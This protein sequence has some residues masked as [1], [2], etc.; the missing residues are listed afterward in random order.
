M[1][2]GGYKATRKG[3]MLIVHDVPIFAVCYRAPRRDLEGEGSE[4]DGHFD[5]KWIRRAAVDVMRRHEEDHYYPP[6]HIR[7]HEDSPFGPGDPARPAGTFAVTRV[8][9]MLFEGEPRLT[10]FADLRFTDPGATYDVEGFRLPFR[11]V[12]ILNIDGKPTIDSLALLDTEV[13]YLKLPNLELGEIVDDPSVPTAPVAHATFAQPWSIESLDGGGPMIACFSQGTRASLL[14]EDTM[15]MTKTKQKPAAKFGAGVINADDKAAKFAEDGD[16]DKPKDEDMEGDDGFDIA[17]VLTAIETRAISLEDWDSLKAAIRK[18]DEASIADET[19]EPEAAPAS[20]PGGESMS[21]REIVKALMKE[22]NSLKAQ[23]VQ[24]KADV[25]AVRGDRQRD[26]D[27]ATAKERLEGRMLGD[28]EQTL[29]QHHKK[30]GREAFKDF[31][32]ELAKQHGIVGDG[33]D[34]ESEFQGASDLAMGF[35][36]RGT[37]AVKLAQDLEAQ[38]KWLVEHTRMAT[39]L[40]DFVKERMEKALGAA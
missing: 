20:L 36:D 18:A 32:E 7:H 33:P 12:E 22:I 21:E 5:E 26:L 14:F 19:E 39:S 2:A 29:L 13:P 37:K 16:D 40:E 35:T 25:G 27:L 4:F 38:H 28:I 34:A 30:H 8:G 31:V 10:I 24:M 3:Q 17:P 11:S 1:D 9:M 15:K 6:M 23:N